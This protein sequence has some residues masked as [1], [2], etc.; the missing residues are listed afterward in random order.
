MVL[1][2]IVFKKMNIALIYESED[3]EHCA[4]FSFMW[5][6]PVITKISAI[7]QEKNNL[8][9]DIYHSFHHRIPTCPP[10]GF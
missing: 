3:D 2:L 5:V 8:Q 4:V 7:N 6:G 9:I 10:I 1:L